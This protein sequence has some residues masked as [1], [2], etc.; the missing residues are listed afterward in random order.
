MRR[1]CRKNRPDAVL[2][3]GGDPLA[4]GATMA[5]VKALDIPLVFALQNFQ[6]H[7]PG[8]L[9]RPIMCG[10]FGVLPTALLEETGVGMSGYVAA[11]RGSGDGWVWTITLTHTRRARGPRR[12]EIGTRIRNK[13]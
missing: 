10:P 4:G 11:G 12:T 9:P 13:P 7:V 8:L 3:Y 5:V 1:F 6:Y 2:S